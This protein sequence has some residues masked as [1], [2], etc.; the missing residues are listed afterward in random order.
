MGFPGAAP[1]AAAEGGGQD[2]GTAVLFGV[3]ISAMDPWGE[4]AAAAPD[5]AAEAAPLLPAVLPPPLGSDGPPLLAFGAALP[6]PFACEPGRGSRLRVEEEEEEDGDL[7]LETLGSTG[8]GRSSFFSASFL[9]AGSFVEG[10]PGC[11]FLRL[12][13]LLPPFDGTAGG[14]GHA[15]APPPPAASIL[16][17]HA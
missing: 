9:G 4:A 12:L 7:L 13:L 5:A 3:D 14:H 17:P 16:N 15:T 1:L 8:L 11:F 10:S 6:D 2:T